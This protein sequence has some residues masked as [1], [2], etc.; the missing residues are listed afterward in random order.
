MMDQF[1]VVE[2][3]SAMKAK[4][5]YNEMHREQDAAR[6]R[7]VLSFDRFERRADMRIEVFIL[8]I[9]L[10]I[11]VMTGCG[12][13]DTQSPETK[14]KAELEPDTIHPSDS[15]TTN[16]SKTSQIQ[17]LPYDG[18]YP[19][20]EAY[21]A[22]IGAM[23]GR[24]V[25]SHNSDSVSWDGSGHWWEISHFDEAVILEMVN[26]SIASLGGKDTAKDG[27]NVLF[28]AN[29][30]ARNMDGGYAEGEKI[31]IKVNIN[32]SAVFDDD[33]SGATQMSYTNPV[34]LKTLLISLVK[35]GGVNP[36]D[37]TV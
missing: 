29:K 37:I 18:N 35:E 19:Q 23:P 27:W 9:I 14:T 34:L 6:M 11:S 22:G 31:A 28:F 16:S 17:S 7:S 26:D 8:V 36:S 4:L 21:G 2:L 24:V 20:H 33:T 3:K 30:N 10:C 32:G 5:N 12:M 1:I 15:M 13:K 25:W